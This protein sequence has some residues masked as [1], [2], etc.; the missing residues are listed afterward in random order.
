MDEDE[1]NCKKLVQELDFS[2]PFSFVYAHTNMCFK[3]ATF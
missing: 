3:R 2:L 1:I